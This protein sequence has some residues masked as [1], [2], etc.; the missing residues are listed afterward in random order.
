LAFNQIDG[1]ALSMETTNDVYAYRKQMKHELD[2]PVEL[3]WN[4]F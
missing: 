4:R 1:T 3:D 2:K